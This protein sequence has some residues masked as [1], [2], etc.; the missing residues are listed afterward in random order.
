MLHE[1]PHPWGIPVDSVAGR[2]QFSRG[3]EAR[4]LSEQ[5]QTLGELPPCS[6]C[7]G[8]EQFRQEL[9]DQMT[10]LSEPHY[11][12]TEW[13]Q[14][15]EKKATGILDQELRRRGWNL[16][17]LKRRRKGDLEKIKI[18][19][20]LRTETTMTL[21]WIAQKLQMGTAGSLGQLSQEGKAMRLCGYGEPTPFW[22]TEPKL[23]EKRSCYP[24]LSG[25]LTVAYS[26]YERYQRTKL[27]AGTGAATIT[28][29]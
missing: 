29:L 20:H 14:T 24:Y 11:A 9:L 2:E 1:E 10:S 23:Y 7:L 12:G 18:A 28:S 21:A 4:R 15:A 6:W 5:A 22:T 25:F 8:S 13:Q 27:A 17:E 16:E 26:V 19:R 3:V